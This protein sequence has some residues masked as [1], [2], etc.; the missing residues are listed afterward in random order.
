MER[1]SQNEITSPYAGR[2]GIH[3]ELGT[4]RDMSCHA[5]NVHPQVCAVKV[6]PRHKT[7]GPNV[8]NVGERGVVRQGH[9]PPKLR[10][11]TTNTGIK[12]K[13]AARSEE[14]ERGVVRQEHS[15]PSPTHYQQK[16]GRRQ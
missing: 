13:Q 9:S 2:V 16:Y 8:Q 6:V 1:G 4:T 14:G 7:Q 15:I 3:R 12:T 11:L 10:P 5:A